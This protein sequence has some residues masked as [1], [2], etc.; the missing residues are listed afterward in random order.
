M[1]DLDTRVREFFD[2][3]QKA[4]AEFDI[5]KI[6][7]CYADAFMFGGP[8]GVQPVRK[9][10][11]IN[12]LP[13]RKE[14]FRSIGLVSSTVVSLEISKLDS[15]YALARAV[16]QMRFERDGIQRITDENSSTYVLCATENRFEIVFQIDHQDLAKKVQELGLK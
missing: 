13:R 15:K 2:C 8:S 4:N 5:Q 14:F 11:F 6:A 10:D 3:Y 1:T 9:E 7:A 16:W 12:V